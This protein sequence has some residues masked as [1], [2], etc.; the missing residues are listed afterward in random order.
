MSAVWCLVFTMFA[1]TV[2]LPVTDCSSIPVY[3]IMVYRG[4]GLS[5]T[6]SIVELCSFWGILIKYYWQMVNMISSRIV[7]FYP[8]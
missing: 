4:G 5:G 7:C 1:I 6:I 8:T 2:F 3:H